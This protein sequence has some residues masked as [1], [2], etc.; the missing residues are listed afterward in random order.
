MPLIAAEAD[1]S[2]SSRSAWSADRVPGQPRQRN[3]SQINEKKN[4][5]TT[6]LLPYDLG[7]RNIFNQDK[8]ATNNSNNTAHTIELGMGAHACSPRLREK[9]CC[10]FRLA[11][12]QT[13]IKKKKKTQSKSGI[14]LHGNAL[15][16]DA[17]LEVS[18]QS[19]CKKRLDL[20]YWHSTN[21]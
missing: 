15:A 11:W 2:P 17:W 21:V 14:Q 3:P 16:W 18:G 19:Q 12:A 4:K 1:G 10:V 20:L 5:P 7:V 13:F 8:T 9:K 6:K